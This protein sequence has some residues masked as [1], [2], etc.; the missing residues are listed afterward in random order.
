MT[1][2]SRGPY[3]QG[4]LHHAGIATTGGRRVKLGRSAGGKGGFAIAGGLAR[5]QARKHC[6]FLC[7]GHFA[8]LNGPSSTSGGG[9]HG[10][11]QRVMSALGRLGLGLGLGS[12]TSAGHAQVH[13]RPEA[14]AHE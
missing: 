10:R 12:S 8:E 1:F 3:R 6:R 13:C 14:L 2:S 11:G 4:P 5:D 7:G 9:H